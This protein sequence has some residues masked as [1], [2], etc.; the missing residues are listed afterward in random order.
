MIVVLLKFLVHIDIETRNVSSQQADIL[1]QY[2]LL[3]A[4]TLH[5]NIHLSDM[6]P[7][8]IVSDIHFYHPFLNRLQSTLQW[9][10]REVHEKQPKHIL[11]LGDTLHTRRDIELHTLHEVHKFFTALLSAPS[12]PQIHLLIGN[13]DMH[14]K[15]NRTV[16]SLDAFDTGHSIKIYREITPTQIDGEKVLFIPYHENQQEIADYLN[17]YKQIRMGDE[18]PET[19][20]FGHMAIN[21]AK[22]NGFSEHSNNEFRG[23]HLMMSMLL[24]FKNVFSGH[25]HHHVSY[26]NGKITYV[27]SPM[28]Q[29]FGDV[30]DEKRGYVW[31]DPSQNRFELKINPHAVHFLREFYQTLVALPSSPI[32]GS[33]NPYEGKFI[34]CVI[35]RAQYAN[36]TD[37]DEVQRKLKSRWKIGGLTPYIVL[38]LASYNEDYDSSSNTTSASVASEFSQQSEVEDEKKHL[39]MPEILTGANAMAD[40]IQQVTESKTPDTRIHIKHFVKS[41]IGSLVENKVATDFHLDEV[42]QTE[43]YDLF[44]ATR[45]KLD[46][47]LVDEQEH[48]QSLYFN[49]NLC[50][51]SICNFMGIRQKL[52]I[53]LKDLPSGLW[54]VVGQNGS[55]K[56]T[57][58]EAIAWCLFGKTF[59]SGL[60]APDIIHDD[61][62]SN[63]ICEVCVTFENGAKVTRRRKKT[64][65]KKQE[66]QLELVLPDQTKVENGSI[67]STQIEIERLIHTNFQAFAKTVVLSSSDTKNFI[68]SSD[69]EKREIIERLL[70]FEIFSPL[71]EQFTQDKKDIAVKIERCNIAKSIYDQKEIS[72]IKSKQDAESDLQSY[73]KSAANLQE[74]SQI[75]SLKL[76]DITDDIDQHEHKREMLQSR[77]TV[78]QSKLNQGN[79]DLNEK[80]QQLTQLK[81]SLSEEL[82]KQ[83]NVKTAEIRLK[84]DIQKDLI[85]KLSAFVNLEAEVV[86][87]REKC[88]E[89]LSRLNDKK[90]E[91]TKQVGTVGVIERTITVHS[92][93]VKTLKQR[94][95]DAT[96]IIQSLEQE[97]TVLRQHLGK[98]TSLKKYNSE[99]SALQTKYDELNDALKNKEYEYKNHECT[100]V[101]NP[102]SELDSVNKQSKV[103]L[104][105]LTVLS[106]KNILDSVNSNKE[107]V[108]LQKQILKLQ[109]EVKLLQQ[110]E[111]SI[112]TSNVMSKD[113]DELKEEKER[114]E[115]A[116]VEYKAL[117]AR[118]QQEISRLLDRIQCITEEDEPNLKQELQNILDEINSLNRALLN[119]KFWSDA[120]SPS[121]NKQ[122][123]KFRSFC[124]TKEIEHINLLLAHNIYL[125]NSDVD[126]FQ[127]HDLNCR[128]TEN[129]EIIQ[130]DSGRGLHK[131]SEGQ[132]KRTDLA[133]FFTFFTIAQE[134]SQFHSSFMIMDEVFDGL[135]ESGQYAV[136][137]WA[138]NML[139]QKHSH[140]SHVFV[141]SHNSH[142]SNSNAGFI[143]VERNSI[144]N[145]GFY[146]IQG[147]E[148]L[149][150]VVFSVDS[151]SIEDLKQTKLQT[152]RKAT[153]KSIAVAITKNTLEKKAKRIV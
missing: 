68:A 98:F 130:S 66:I 121:T 80:N 19:I 36:R 32:R 5:C 51:L 57:I 18:A 33:D 65:A 99:L 110:E 21:G 145:S 88:R 10:I 102:K 41:Y 13:H 106:Q 61:C 109:K 116:M 77:L 25:F 127:L 96:D 93:V 27:G 113:Q 115:H 108:E 87:L 120:L 69:K 148:E 117:I 47:E 22:C 136:Q 122:R 92:D 62:E 134:R 56:S 2:F 150:K 1:I 16:T 28:Q 112:R 105:E 49:A 35:T 7:W 8:F 86:S 70:G 140:L 128:I 29:N 52:T 46:C 141:I 132:R 142:T 75:V 17:N 53:N 100:L 72:I 107:I 23:G 151:K 38:D 63:E 135:D 119:V 94:Y 14:L 39:N 111:R 123:D 97:S 64:L 78:V 9:L 143:E 152:K 138:Q 50:T 91:S 44:M 144:S 58:G 71:F 48:Q 125:L 6:K 30:G 153:A 37:Y 54:I 42:R 114:M 139:L 3:I 15:H 147:N 89:S 40:V 137:R 129:L 79:Q 43:L 101:T 85:D 74:Q 126:G 90:Q 67:D 31:Y 20:V 149:S 133:V 82:T 81:N 34:Q 12:K 83:R 4:I 73:K 59:R 11:I 104:Q 103:L 55:G 45:K 95:P 76:N 118:D 131:R 26:V 84:M 146:K 24:G 60:L 124:L